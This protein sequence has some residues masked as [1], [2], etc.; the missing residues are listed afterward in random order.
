METTTTAQ[1]QELGLVVDC[2][3]SAWN[4]SIV[5][6]RGRRRKE[7][8]HEKEEVDESVAQTTC[9]ISR[10][11]PPVDGMVCDASQPARRTMETQRQDFIPML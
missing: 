7:W 10:H 3:V 2:D 6:G 4:T 11:H 5:G 1:E 8:E 9:H